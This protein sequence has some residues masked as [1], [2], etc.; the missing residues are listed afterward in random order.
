MTLQLKFKNRL[1]PRLIAMAKLRSPIRIKPIL[2]AR[3]R[4]LKRLSEL[5]EK[6]LGEIP[7]LDNPTK[8]Q[9]DWYERKMHGSARNWEVWNK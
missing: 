4:H 1:G 2:E 5:S 7:Q 3:E 6:S 9:N 8:E